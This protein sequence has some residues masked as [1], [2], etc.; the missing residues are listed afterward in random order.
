MR[1]IFFGCIIGIVLLGFAFE[2]YAQENEKPTGDY[3]ISEGDVLSINVRGEQE[4]TVKG[5]QVRIDGRI[6]LPSI[7]EIHVSGKTSAQLEAEITERLKI[8]LKEPIV[9][10]FID[11]TNHKVT[12]AGKVG[13]PGNYALMSPNT[14]VL[15]ILMT[16]GG[17]SETAKS[18]NIKI[19]RYV[20]GKEVQFLFNYKEVLQG[21]NLKQNI[22]VENRDWIMVP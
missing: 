6:T 10:V 20:N 13:R 11:K 19:V 8:H 2:L 5:T 14:T 12:V 21:K 16:A 1:N 9:Q 3:I 15:E 22:L 7:G 18:K 17:P 4:Y